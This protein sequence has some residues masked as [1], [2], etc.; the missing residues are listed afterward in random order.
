MKRLLAQQ[1]IPLGE[2]LKGIGRLGLENPEEALSLFNKFLS[3]T[4]GLLTIIAF[5]WFTFKLILGAISIIGAGSDKTA[6]ENAR[7]DI[8]TSI[9]GLVVVIAAVFVIDL[10]GKILGIDNI[11]NPAEMLGQIFKL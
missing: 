5:I 9:V 7:K 11:L 10:I 2:P 4:I 1:E 8:T 3:S 6:L